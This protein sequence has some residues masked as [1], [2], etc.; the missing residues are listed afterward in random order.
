MYCFFFILFYNIRYN[1]KPF[2]ITSFAI[3]KSVKN[4]KI[5]LDLTV[6]PGDEHLKTQKT[7]IMN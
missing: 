7:I 1:S 2:Q 6:L 5:K 3:D 4:K